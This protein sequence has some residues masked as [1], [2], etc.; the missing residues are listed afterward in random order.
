MGKDEEEQCG[1]VKLGWIYLNPAPVTPSLRAGLR[2]ISQSAFEKGVL[3]EKNKA[4]VLF[5]ADGCG[6]KLVLVDVVLR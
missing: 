5:Y 3:N 2:G 1:S 6:H 4:Y